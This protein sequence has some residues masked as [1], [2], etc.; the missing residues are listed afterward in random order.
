MGLIRNGT[1]TH[2]GP[3][4]GD[5]LAVAPNGTMVAVL[6]EASTLYLFY[7]TDEGASWAAV[8]DIP[9]SLTLDQQFK[10]FAIAVDG[11]NQFHLFV[12]YIDLYYLRF[13]VNASTGAMENESNSQAWFTVDGQTTGYVTSAAAFYWSGNTTSYAVV[14]FVNDT[15]GPSYSVISCTAAGT[16]AIH[17][18]EVGWDATLSS[19]DNV[20]VDFVHTGDGYTPTTLPHL[21]LA[22]SQAGNL[23]VRKATASGD[24]PVWAA[25]GDE[26]LLSTGNPT[27]RNGHVAVRYNATDDYAY[28]LGNGSTS[29]QANFFRYGPVTGTPSGFSRAAPYPTTTANVNHAMTMHTAEQ[30]IYLNSED[31]SQNNA[32][33]E[34]NILNNSWQDWVEILPGSGGNLL[35]TNASGG[36]RFVGTD[37]WLHYNYHNPSPNFDQYA[38]RRDILGPPDQPT[39]NNTNP[40]VADIN[41][42]LT[43]DWN[44]IGQTGFPQLE[45]FLRRSPGI[46]STAARN[47]ILNPNSSEFWSG[48]GDWVGTENCDLTWQTSFYQTAPAAMQVTVKSSTVDTR[49]GWTT[50]MTYSAGVS[51]EEVLEKGIPIDEYHLYGISFRLRADSGNGAA[52]TIYLYMDYYDEDGVYLSGVA[53]ATSTQTPGTWNGFNTFYASPPSGARWALPLFYMGSAEAVATESFNI[54]NF[55]VW[56]DGNPTGYGSPNPEFWDAGAS[57]FRR[58]RNLLDLNVDSRATDNNLLIG[59]STAPKRAIQVVPTYTVYG[60]TQ[61]KVLVDG[62]GTIGALQPLHCRLYQ[63]GAEPEAGSLLATSSSWSFPVGTAAGTDVVATFTFASPQTLTASTSYY[64]MVER[65]NQTTDNTNYYRFAKVAATSNSVYDY[66]GHV[67][68]YHSGAAWVT[69]QPAA[70][71]EIV[72]DP[73]QVSGA[74]SVAVPAGW[75][76]DAN[77]EDLFMVQTKHITLNSPPSRP[78][79]VNPSVSYN[80]TI[81]APSGTIFTGNNTVSWSVTEQSRK[82]IKVARDAGIT[83]IEYDSTVLT[84]G[85]KSHTTPFTEQGPRWIWVQTYNNEFLPCDT[86]DIQAV[87]VSGPIPTK[88]KITLTLGDGFI[89]V[90]TFNP[91]HTPPNEADTERQEIWRR[92]VGAPGQGLRLTSTLAENGTFRDWA[93]ASNVDYEYQAIAFNDTESSSTASYWI[94]GDETPTGQLSANTANTVRVS[95]TVT[96]YSPSFVYGAVMAPTATSATAAATVTWAGLVIGQ[97]KASNANSAVGAARRDRLGAAKGSNANIAKVSATV[98]GSGAAWPHDTV[99]VLSRTTGRDDTSQ[100]THNITLP[101]TVAA[102]NVWLIIA[103]SAK[104]TPS[105]TWAQNGLSCWTEIADEPYTSNDVSIHAAWKRASQNDGGATVVLTTSAATKIVYAIYRLDNVGY[106]FVETPALAIA[107]TANPNPPNVAPVKL[108]WASNYKE[109]L[110]LAAAGTTWGRDFTADPSGYTNGIGDTNPGFND[111][112]IRSVEKTVFAASEDPPNFTIE[113]SESSV[114]GTF[115]IHPSITKL[116]GYLKVPSGD[117]SRL[118]TTDSGDFAPASV[119]T[120]HSL[121]A[122]FTYRNRPYQ[123]TLVGQWSASNQ[124]WLLTVGATAAD[125]PRLYWST[126]GSDTL[127]E[128]STAGIAGISDGDRVQFRADFVPDNGSQRTVDYYY[129]LNSADDIVSNTG[130]TAMGT[131]RTGTQTTIYDGTA[132]MAIGRYNSGTSDR[133]MVEVFQAA[134]IVGGT[135]DRFWLDLRDRWLDRNYMVDS[136]GHTW[137]MG[138]GWAHPV[139]PNFINT[140]INSAGAG[141][142]LTTTFPVATTAGNLLV[143]AFFSRGNVH[144]ITS[145]GWTRAFEKTDAT[146]DDTLEVWYKEADGTETTVVG[147]IQ[148]GETGTDL[149]W[150]GEYPG[151]YTALDRTVQFAQGDTAGLTIPASA[152]NEGS[153]NPTGGTVTVTLPG[154]PRPGDRY[155]ILATGNLTAASGSIDWTAGS[156]VGWET[157]VDMP[158][159]LNSAGA[160]AF[161]ASRV[162]DPYDPTTQTLEVSG[163]NHE[164]L[165]VGAYLLRPAEGKHISYVS[166]GFQSWNNNSPASPSVTLNAAPASGDAVL[167]AISVWSNNS[168]STWLHGAVAMTENSETTFGANPSHGA[169]ASVVTSGTS[170]TVQTT[171]TTANTLVGMVAGA[172]RQSGSFPYIRHSTITTQETNSTSHAVSMQGVREGDRAFLWAVHGEG[173]VLTNMP[174][175]WNQLANLSHTINGELWEKRWCTGNERDFTYTTG[176]SQN[177]ISRVLFVSGSDPHAASEVA[178]TSGSAGYPNG[179]NVTP[180]WGAL[181]TLWMSLAGANTNNSVTAYPANYAGNQFYQGHAGTDPMMTANATRELNATSENPLTYTLNA[182]DDWVA[183]TLAVKPGFLQ[184]SGRMLPARSPDTIALAAFSQRA[185][186]L[187][188]GVFTNQFVE[189]RQLVASDGSPSSLHVASARSGWSD[190]FRFP[191]YNNILR[192]D[193]WRDDSNPTPTAYRSARNANGFLDLTMNVSGGGSSNGPRVTMMLEHPIVDAEISGTVQTRTTDG[194]DVAVYL[195]A[196]GDWAGDVPRWGYGVHFIGNSTNVA[197]YKLVDGTQTQIGSTFNRPG[198]TGVEHRFRY[199]VEGD[200]IKVKV[201]AKTD[202]EPAAWTREAT[203]TDV[204]KRPGFPK[205]GTWGSADATYRYAQVGFQWTPITVQNLAR[206]T[207]AQFTQTGGYSIGSLTAFAYNRPELISSETGFNG[208]SSTTYTVNKPVDAQE[209][210]LLVVHILGSSSTGPITA[211]PAGWTEHTNQTNGDYNFWVGSKTV[212]ASEPASWDWTFGNNNFAAH[213]IDLVFNGGTPEAFNVTTGTATNNAAVA[214]TPLGLDR[215]ILIYAGED[216]S[217]TQTWSSNIAHWKTVQ[218]TLGSEFLH[219]GGWGHRNYATSQY[220]FT[221]TTTST[222]Q[223][224]HTAAIVIPPGS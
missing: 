134:L 88:P 219:I 83:D 103:I 141:N 9:V 97:P 155:V 115:P 201:W 108:G 95:A 172:F 185:S 33:C 164:S 43:L 50:G 99:T 89:D 44:Y 214:V 126:T 7:S 113:A 182:T 25:T 66:D 157:H 60:V 121:R 2:Y 140:A 170:T 73:Y 215:L 181:N 61:F 74:T 132:D 195:R 98:T 163:G 224:L 221:Q 59:Y 171:V 129:K 151:P 52:R 106:P 92:V 39:W 80:P 206:E 133:E 112:S 165:W 168:V 202:P 150:I 107:T 102:G 153:G 204:G 124:Q 47:M 166:S 174:E 57:T 109:Y 58:Y 114:A 87:D 93:A 105:A 203:D 217:T 154:T 179:T 198:G 72:I 5:N 152:F 216:I 144:T 117:N 110:I 20:S 23:L 188:A 34:Y 212:G 84:S 28:I 200:E 27:T 65:D 187:S 26:V 38:T 211:Y 56:V 135:D 190:D 191:G 6:Q 41:Q 218:E 162:W 136:R 208:S 197:I 42:T 64:F 159:S 209:G 156:G 8:S 158:G 138:T 193:L 15:S 94:S 205:I 10:A 62:V 75:A 125:R 128:D 21:V 161:L 220:T 169:F 146:N 36:A 48:L 183:I 86:P 12:Q 207:T 13:T 70:Q 104:N 142:T 49:W 196:S 69:A 119:G 79:L 192:N 30:K 71:Y 19:V 77:V 68:W 46:N 178:T 1:T 173:G 82:H 4:G 51:T 145:T 160:V 131:Q 91:T 18:S 100:T 139:Q 137:S 123:R 78:L 67:A 186:G 147:D 76:T 210:E 40:Q 194:M 122:E 223:D 55:I 127:S 96:N 120:V 176:A 45:Y 11:N 22:W 180:S 90:G 81:S 31:A 16:T 101:A 17:D 37:N 213:Q 29:T 118:Y 32:W 35:D 222:S 177:S 3:A 130:W 116:P 111:A 167:A 53:E 63:G 175:G 189:E 199:R 54:D 143:A 14:A 149:L 184:T 24:P 148:D 85:V